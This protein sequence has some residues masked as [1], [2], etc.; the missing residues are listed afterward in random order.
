MRKFLLAFCC[1]VLELVSPV[2]ASDAV[3]V[4]AM[5]SVPVYFK[6]D[7]NRRE[8]IVEAALPASSSEFGRL[9]LLFKLSCPSNS[10]DRWDRLGSFGLM[11][12]G[13]DGASSYLELL[14]FV[15]PYAIGANWSFDLSD[16]LPLLQ[17]RQK[18]KVFI[19]TWVG[20]GH[21]QGNGW[22]VDA[23][24][25]YEEAK[26]RPRAAYV[27]PLL[28]LEDVVYG[29]PLRSSERKAEALPLIGYSS[30]KLYTVITGHGQGNAE[31]CAEFCPKTHTVNLGTARF[32]K[33]VWRDNCA[34]TVDPNQ[35][36][37]WRYPRAGWCP[38]DKVEPWTVDITEALLAGQTQ[39]SYQPEP[40]DNSCRPG[41]SD[42]KACVFGTSCDFDGG[43]HT[44]PRYYVSSF[45]IYYR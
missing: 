33:R 16:F 5:Q 9:T 4:P 13:P 12:A 35:K 25:V 11:Q 44:E 32:D 10:C 28:S 37:S 14:R 3:R 8:Q 22:L 17:G 36:G 40:F 39:V 38:G 26:D 20:P 1:G 2:L 34:T 42:C 15:T 41:S 45:I 24:L 7:D 31:N 6:G 27:Q 19:D 21:P 29:D 23:E 43:L 30:A 18:F